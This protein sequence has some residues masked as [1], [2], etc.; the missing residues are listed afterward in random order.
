MKCTRLAP[1]EYC[2]TA[3]M[4]NGVLCQYLL[5]RRVGGWKLSRT[6]PHAVFCGM[7]PTKSAALAEVRS[8]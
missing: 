3:R 1:A 4:Y 2:V 6:V 8:C 5:T 7:F